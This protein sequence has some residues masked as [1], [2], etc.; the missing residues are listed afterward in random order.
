MSNSTTSTSPILLKED[1]PYRRMSVIEQKN[2]TLYSLTKKEYDSFNSSICKL[3]SFIYKDKN[4]TEMVNAASNMHELQTLDYFSHNH[5]CEET[6]DDAL[7]EI[8]NMRSLYVDVFTKLL[9]RV[10]FEDK[11]ITYD[12]YYYC[13][14]QI[15]N[16]EKTFT[17]TDV[18]HFVTPLYIFGRKETDKILDRVKYGY[19][20]YDVKHSSSLIV[21]HIV[22]ANLYYG[23]KDQALAWLLLLKPEPLTDNEIQSVHEAVGMFV[24]NLEF[25]HQ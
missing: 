1:Y 2:K 16:H 4:N 7:M 23:F 24:E 10:V 5:T 14:E 19:N 21:W 3:L 12:N 6:L 18:N 13:V 8:E 9:Q 25:M 17:W 20:A 22:R 11:T 15:V